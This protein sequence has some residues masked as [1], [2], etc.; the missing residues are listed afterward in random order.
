MGCIYYT[1]LS[2]MKR[3]LTATFILIFLSP[4]ILRAFYDGKI[5]PSG[6]SPF[7]SPSDFVPQDTMLYQGFEDTFPPSGWDTLEISGTQGG[8]NP[9]PWCKNDYYAHTDSFSATYGWG[10]NLDGWLRILSLDFSQVYDIQLSFWWISSYT[11]HVYPYDNGDLFVE[12]STDAGATWDTLWTF[13]D[14]VCVVGSGVTW[15]WEDWVW[16]QSTLDLS[17]YA[18]MSNIYIG[19]HVVADD[20]ADIAIDDVV[21]DT[22]SYT[23]VEKETETSPYGT[24]FLVLRPNPVITYSRISF[25]LPEDIYLRLAIYDCTGRVVRILK[26]GRTG[27]GYH[28]IIWDKRDEEGKESA[29]GVYF[30]LLTAGPFELRKKFIIPY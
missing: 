30:C 2:K 6:V 26:K 10:Y 22:T 4:L 27:R 12:V 21:I 13:G 18:D 28:N 15:P 3:Y 19:F 11:W 1:I 14:S 23:V 7:S 9:I 5:I 8:P 20:N 16:Y 24:P 17:E 29:P 25:Y